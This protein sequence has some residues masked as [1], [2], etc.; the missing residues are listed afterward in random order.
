MSPQDGTFGRAPETIIP[1][2]KKGIRGLISVFMEIQP[3]T[4]FGF[5]MDAER[6]QRT[7]ADHGEDQV[8]ARM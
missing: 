2:G 1:D 8:T 5:G 7:S 4:G 6:E 3:V